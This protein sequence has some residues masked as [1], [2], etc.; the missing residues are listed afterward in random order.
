LARFSFIAVVD[1]FADIKHR[2]CPTR[3]EMV[4]EEIGKQDVASLD[5]KAVCRSKNLLSI[6]D[7]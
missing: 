7:E 5:S 2:R 4:A 3:R 1:L 6:E